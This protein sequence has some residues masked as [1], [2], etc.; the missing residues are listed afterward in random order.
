MLRTRPQTA[1][2]RHPIPLRIR[3]G[4]ALL[5]VGLL[6]A[7]LLATVKADASSPQGDAW[8][9]RATGSGERRRVESSSDL[10]TGKPERTTPLAAREIARR[11]SGRVEVRL[12]AE[13]EVARALAAGRADY[14]RE[15]D[16]ALDWLSR[17][18]PPRQ[19]AA[20]IELTLVSDRERTRMRRVHPGGTATVVD[21]AAA[22]G[23][24]TGGNAPSAQ[25]G[26]ALAIALHE[27]SHATAALMPQRPDRADDEYRAS[28]V[29][30]CYLVD[31]LRPGDTLR[32]RSGGGA[33]R[34]DEYFVSAASRKASEDVVRDMARAAGGHEVAWHDQTA[35]LGLKTLCRIRLAM[36]AQGL[37]GSAGGD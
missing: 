32:L 11:A 19:P 27:A 7:G 25:I 31:T 29:E 15:L 12:H 10:N 24:G 23:L 17:L 36:A 22:V 33:A 30:S 8:Q 4:G 28:L 2:Q 20:R 37:D 18:P 5:G 26:Q 9:V 13:P 14:G 35:L 16:K 6:A 3:R 34:R 1:R 21:I